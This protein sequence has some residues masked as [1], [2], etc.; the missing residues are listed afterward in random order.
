MPNNVNPV[1]TAET[2]AKVSDHM[3]CLKNFGART[4]IAHGLGSEEIPLEIKWGVGDDDYEQA[5]DKNGDDIKLTSSIRSVTVYG[6]AIL[7]LNKPTTSNPVTVSY[8]DAEYG[9]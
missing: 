6:P 2:D 5:T 8:V 9:V 1:F 7:R 3:Y 4:F